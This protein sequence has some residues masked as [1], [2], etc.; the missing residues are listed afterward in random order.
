VVALGLNR[1]RTGPAWVVAVLTVLLTPPLAWAAL[2]GAVWAGYR[3]EDWLSPLTGDPA[4]F[5]GY[6]MVVI[7]AAAGLTMAMLLVVPGSWWG[8]PVRPGT[9]SGPRF[10]A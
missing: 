7:G 9:R 8:S 6:P 5:D 4:M 1:P 10:R 3:A 2:S